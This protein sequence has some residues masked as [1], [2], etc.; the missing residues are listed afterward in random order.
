MPETLYPILGNSRLMLSVPNRVGETEPRPV[1]LDD[2]L[3][4][5][6]IRR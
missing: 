6:E 5:L 4:C 2:V 1:H 3:Y